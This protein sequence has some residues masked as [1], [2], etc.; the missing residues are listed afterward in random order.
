MTKIMFLETLLDY[1]RK[2]DLKYLIIEKGED[3]VL[4]QPFLDKLLNIE[5]KKQY[6]YNTRNPKSISKIKNFIN[7][8]YT[9]KIINFKDY[10]SNHFIDSE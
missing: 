5:N 2:V 7:N 4:T 8:Y 9:G 6:N 1:L 10:H 3:M